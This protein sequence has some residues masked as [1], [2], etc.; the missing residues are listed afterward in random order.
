MLIILNQYN[1]YN[2]MNVAGEYSQE[3]IGQVGKLE[4]NSGQH[5]KLLDDTR[6]VKKSTGKPK[7]NLIFYFH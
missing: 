4:E 7:A 3:T 5:H 2:M 1:A 6:R